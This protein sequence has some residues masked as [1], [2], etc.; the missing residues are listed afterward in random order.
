VK[1]LDSQLESTKWTNESMNVISDAGHD[2]YL[3]QS[4]MKQFHV[5]RMWRHDLMMRQ[6]ILDVI[7]KQDM[8]LHMYVGFAILILCQNTFIP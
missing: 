7:C 3:Y 8:E 6:H 5:Q 4:Q 2:F 1:Q